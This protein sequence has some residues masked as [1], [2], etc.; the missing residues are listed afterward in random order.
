MHTYNP[1]AYNIAIEKMPMAMLMEHVMINH[2]SI[3]L[4]LGLYMDQALGL[5]WGTRENSMV[6]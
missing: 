6:D 2:E 1:I 3:S 5:A 4:Q